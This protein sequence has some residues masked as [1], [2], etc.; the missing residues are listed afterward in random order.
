MSK[1]IAAM[2]HELIIRGECFS[3]SNPDS[4]AKDWAERFSVSVAAC[5]MDYGFWDADAAESCK[6]A[7]YSPR[8]MYDIAKDQADRG[9]EYSS[10]DLIYALCNGDASV[11]D[12]AK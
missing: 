2:K 10:G 7:G 12:I 6:D 4:I 3:G 8:K 9:I 5:W 11:D 1:K